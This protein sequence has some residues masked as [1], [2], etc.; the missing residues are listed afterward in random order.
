[1]H[2]QFISHRKILPGTTGCVCNVFRPPL[3]YVPGHLLELLISCCLCSDAVHFLWRR[4][5]A[6]YHCCDITLHIWVTVD[7]V[8]HIVLWTPGQCIRH[9][10]GLSWCVLSPQVE[11]HQPHKESLAAD[12]HIVE[13]FGV[14]QWN[15]WF[16]ICN[17]FECGEAIEVFLK[18]LTCPHARQTLLFHLAISCFSITQSPGA[19]SHRPSVIAMELQQD[20]A[21]TIAAC[22][23]GH[24]SLLMHIKIH[25]GGWCCEGP[26]YLFQSLLLC[27]PPCPLWLWLQQFIKWLAHCG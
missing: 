10:Q 27:R 24:D 25:Q 22:V 16:V 8:Y 18:P 23:C 4:R 11:P 7:V 17:Q 5:H 14:H 12:W 19:V 21:Y 9:D 13:V 15:E 3:L 26:F 6:A 2:W 1:M 20:A